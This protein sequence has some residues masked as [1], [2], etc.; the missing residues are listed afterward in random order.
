MN[1]ATHPKS[2]DIIAKN[3]LK[4]KGFKLFDA[5]NAKFEWLIQNFLSKRSLNMIYAGAGSGKSM[6]ALYLCDYLLKNCDDQIDEIIYFDADN[7]NDILLSRNVSQIVERSGGKLNYVMSNTLERFK[8]FSRLN[9]R[10]KLND[11]QNK[12]II[13][14]SI[15]NFMNFNLSKDIQVT[16]FLSDLQGIRDKGATIIFLHHQ[17]KQGYDRNNDAY[18]GATAFIDS[19]DEAYYLQN[20]TDNAVVIN[21]NKMILSLRPKKRRSNTKNVVVLLDTKNLS[22]N[23]INDDLV[24]LNDK[25]KVSLQLA[26]DIIDSKGEIS[27]SE[28]AIAI[29]KLANKNYLE[30]VG[31]NTLWNLFNRFDGILFT[32]HRQ[33]GFSCNK[34]I[35]KKLEISE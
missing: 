34:K 30:I 4:S 17:P 7:G 33:K 23:F 9:K 27:Q 32:I 1:S 22:L 14:D 24:G 21:D 3:V 11:F 5:K 18:K 12:I 2:L 15:R 16:K 35:F 28:L 31:R 19:V 26:K 10:S 6:F 8:I 25:E 20:E 29:Q 13:I